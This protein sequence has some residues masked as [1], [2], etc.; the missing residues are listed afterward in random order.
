MRLL[1]SYPVIIG[2]TGETIVVNAVPALTER[3]A[4]V[5][6]L[7]GCFFDDL[8]HIEGHSIC[9]TSAMQTGACAGRS[10]VGV[11]PKLAP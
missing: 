3:A 2:V 1:R 5:V 4:W 11:T 9:D 7:T 10:H 6:E 8:D